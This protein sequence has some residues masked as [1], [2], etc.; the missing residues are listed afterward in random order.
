[1][2]SRDVLEARWLELVRVVLPGLAAERSWPVRFDHCF[3]RILLD[4][5]CGGCW[6]DHLP[7]RPAYRHLSAAQLEAAVALAESVADGSADLVALNDRS[8]AWRAA[9]RAR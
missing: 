5:L 2:P 4:H 9:R 1:M 6:Y 8:L 3:A 7:A